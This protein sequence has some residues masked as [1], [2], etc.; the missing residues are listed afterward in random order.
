[1]G[2]RARLDILE[3]KNISLV[4]TGIRAPDHPAHSTATT[5]TTVCTYHYTYIHTQTHTQFRNTNK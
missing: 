1:M 5:P 2:P 4:P 3:M